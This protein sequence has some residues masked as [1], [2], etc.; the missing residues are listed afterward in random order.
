MRSVARRN[1]PLP[2]AVAFDRLTALRNHERLIPLTTISTPDRRPAVGDR[3]RRHVGMAARDTMELV[4]YEPPGDD[5]VGRARWVKRGPVLLGEAEIVV[6]AVA[7]GC[8][9]EW[10]E[11][12]IVEGGLPLTRAPLTGADGHD[13]RDRARAVRPTVRPSHDPRHGQTASARPPVPW[14]G[15]PSHDVRM[16]TLPPPLEE[17]R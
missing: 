7:A 4:G 17:I 15:S 13:D 6:T 9:V 10:V 3:H 12:D 2:V 8:R 1:L 5:G 11:R 14:S 16:A